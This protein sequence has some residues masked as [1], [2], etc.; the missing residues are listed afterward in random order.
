[1][2]HFD[3]KV[4]AYLLELLQTFRD[5]ERDVDQ[6]PVG[7]V[8]KHNTDVRLELRPGPDLLPDHHRI[9]H[10][11]FIVLEEDVGLEIINGLIDDVGVDS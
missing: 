6:R 11:D 1:M 10:L 3:L 2:C 9:H 7:L 5:V 4:Q 8:L